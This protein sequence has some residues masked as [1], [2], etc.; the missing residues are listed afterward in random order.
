LQ[1][2]LSRDWARLTAALPLQA[3]AQAVRRG[4]TT[5][6][7]T[8]NTVPRQDDNFVGPVNIGFNVNY[9]AQSWSQ[10]FVNQNGNVTFGAGLSEFTPFSL[11]GNT[12]LPDHRRVLRGRGHAQPAVG[13]DDLRHGH[14]DGRAAFGVNWDGVGYFDTQAD[15][16]NIFQLILV[17][18]SDTGAGN[19]D[20][21]FNYDQILWETG[22]AS[23]GTNGFG[24][25]SAAVGYSQ[26]TGVPAPSRSVPGSLVNGALSTA[27]P[28]RS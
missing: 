14:A 20:I 28:T 18:R 15:K 23:G 11:T 26:G 6:G 8:T 12:G 1:R 21:E 2:S 27:A 13:G 25:T 9:N 24:G 10:L 16:L 19:F 4:G 3:D 17:D 5:S 22:S 7:F